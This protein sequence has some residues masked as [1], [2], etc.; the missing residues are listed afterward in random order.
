MSVF[1]LMKGK[2][3]NVEYFK[4]FLSG[5][6]PDVPAFKVRVFTSDFRFL[7]GVKLILVVDILTQ[8]LLTFLALIALPIL[9]KTST[10]CRWFLFGV[11]YYVN[12][13]FTP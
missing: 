9:R 13:Q 12:F 2:M 3:A 8:I 1:F 11:S 4:W 6:S 5:M 7:I 10:S